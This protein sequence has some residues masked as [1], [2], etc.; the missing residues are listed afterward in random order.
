MPLL[1]NSTRLWASS[2]ARAEAAAVANGLARPGDR[3]RELP[4]AHHLQPCACCLCRADRP[5][6]TISLA[7]TA[8]GVAYVVLPPDYVCPA[9]EVEL[10]D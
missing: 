2:L 10:I 6:H 5:A 4:A 7:G 9:A 8:A 1:Q 3:V